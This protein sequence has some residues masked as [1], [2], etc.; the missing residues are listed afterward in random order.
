[1]S[2]P[3][4][5][6]Q[7]C[8]VIVLPSA[9]DPKIIYYQ[10]KSD[11]NATHYV[12]GLQDIPSLFMSVT[13]PSSTCI[14]AEEFNNTIDWD[15]FFCDDNCTDPSCE[16]VSDSCNSGC[17]F[18]AVNISGQ[19]GDFAFA[20]T[21]NSLI[22][23]KD[24]KSKAYKAF[25]PKDL[26]N[27]ALYFNYSL[28]NLKWSFNENNNQLMTAAPNGLTWY[29]SVSGVLVHVCEYTCTYFISCNFG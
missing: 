1:M 11:T 17:N 19:D 16:T 22:E 25:K 27:P 2:Q 3:L 23:F 14:T 10:L 5:F 8:D 4:S 28:A 21:F 24:I 29:I 15:K 13:G 12:W 7:K 6:S 26:G 20:L 18:G 9:D